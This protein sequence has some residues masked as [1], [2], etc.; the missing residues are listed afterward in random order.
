MNKLG[1]LLLSLMIISNSAKTS[2]FTTEKNYIIP[3]MSLGIAAAIYYYWPGDQEKII[4][5]HLPDAS[6]NNFENHKLEKIANNKRSSQEFK[7]KGE[8]SF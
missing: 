7:Y 4:D 6:I 3:L 1:Y 5:E 8:R 2:N